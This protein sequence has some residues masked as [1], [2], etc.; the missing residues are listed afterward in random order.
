VALSD[1][2][3]AYGRRMHPILSGAYTR[4]RPS[5]SRGQRF[6]PEVYTAEEMNRI[7]AN[8]GRGNA[9]ARNKAAFALMYRSGLRAMEVIG[10]ELKDIDFELG[11]V[12]VMHGKGNKRRLVPLDEHTAALIKLWLARRAALGIARRGPVFCTIEKGMRGRPVSYQQLDASFKRAGARAGIEKRLH[13]HGLRHSCAFDLRREGYDPLTICQVLGHSDLRVTQRYLNH[14]A[15]LDMI[16]AL[17]ARAWP[18][19]DAATLE[20]RAVAA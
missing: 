10:L 19:T 1:C 17:S 7:L 18:A 9:G 15:P 12:T 6:Q 13:L 16:R 2:P 3:P 20:H 8:C 4:G 11:A 14:I 5:P